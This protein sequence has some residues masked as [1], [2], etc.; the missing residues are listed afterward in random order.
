MQTYF[1]THI[2]PNRKKQCLSY[3][4]NSVRCE[5]MII[6]LQWLQKLT[7]PNSNNNYSSK[8]SD[9]CI[10]LLFQRTNL[11]PFHP[12]FAHAQWAFPIDPDIYSSHPFVLNLIYNLFP[13]TKLHICQ[14]L[15]RL[16]KL[17]I[18]S[19]TGFETH[20]PYPLSLN[21]CNMA[22]LAATNSLAAVLASMYVL[23]LRRSWRLNFLQRAL[24][25]VNKFL[26][27]H[28]EKNDFSILK[29]KNNSYIITVKKLLVDRYIWRTRKS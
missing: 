25:C 18:S 10:K 20:F 13:L 9:I 11:R 8:S 17:N 19:S 15:Q 7:N 4:N 14:A 6:L 24:K 28:L 23:R 16:S 12:S 5:D 21:L 1:V 26:F 29:Y 22:S 3:K 2:Y 27:E